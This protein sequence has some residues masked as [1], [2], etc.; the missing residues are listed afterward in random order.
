M[1]VVQFRLSAVLINLNA[2]PAKFVYRNIKC[3][4][5]SVTA[6]IIRTK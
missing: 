3:A 5:I 1:Y 4:T 2:G 6:K